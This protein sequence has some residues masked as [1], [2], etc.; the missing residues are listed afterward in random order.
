MA[1]PKRHMDVLERVSGG[2]PR[3]TRKAP[4]KAIRRETWWLPGLPKA[5]WRIALQ[6]FNLSKIV[7]IRMRVNL[8]S[9]C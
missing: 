5:N 4:R 3:K 9:N 7:N 6:N 1:E 8:S 2:V